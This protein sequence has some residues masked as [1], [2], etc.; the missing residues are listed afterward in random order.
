MRDFTLGL[1]GLAVWATPLAAQEPTSRKIPLVVK[2]LQSRYHV[3]G[4][5]T[6]RV[7]GV[8]P[9]RD[10]AD[11][12]GIEQKFFPGAVV[13]SGF[14]DWRTVSRYRSHAGLHLGY[15]IAMPYGCAFGAGWSGVVTG[16]A[17]WSGEEHGISVE[18]PDGT[19]VTYGHVAPKVVV[20]Q[21]VVAG[22]I[23]GTIALDHVDVKMR[24]PAG[25]YQDF[26][27]SGRIL[28]A[29][30]WA[31]GGWVAVR[32][33]RES[34][35]AEWLMAANSF[36]LAKEELEQHR[37]QNTQR[38][39]EVEQLRR[40]IPALKK[41]VDM[42]A[43]Y[44]EQGLVARVTAEENREELEKARRRLKTLEK[45][46]SSYQVKSLEAN[47]KNARDRLAQAKLAAQGRGLTFQDVERFVA[48]TI[49]NDKALRRN[50]EAYKKAAQAKNAAQLAKIE[51]QLRD[52][53]KNL[54]SLEELFDIGGIA[55]N[56]LITSRAKHKLLQAQLRAL[57]AQTQ[58]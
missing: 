22:Q 57:K 26:G 49:N 31:A 2:Q 34:V 23:L 44:I 28:P 24:D 14:Y 25:N 37:R 55:K 35:M 36:D 51:G 56:D 42:M 41:S 7:E 19:T 1:V 18:S 17:V 54:K 30:S 58:D 40:R 12:V 8:R 6:M 9:A 13:T 48:A 46:S 50:V 53:D 15:D 45:E 20:G 21:H 52:S 4:P 38:K 10:L 33:T 5:T 47:L 43:E 29:P 32:A 3:P 16:I 27:G 11:L 39:L